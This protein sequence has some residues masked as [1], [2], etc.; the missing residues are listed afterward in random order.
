MKQKKLIELPKLKQDIINSLYTKYSKFNDLVDTILNRKR[1]EQ[2]AKNKG[3][4]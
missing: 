3:K 2:D 1:K 4:R